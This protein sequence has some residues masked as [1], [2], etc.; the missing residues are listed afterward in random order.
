MIEAAGTSNAFQ[1]A[2]VAARRGGRVVLLGLPG[3]PG[4]LDIFRLVSSERELIGSLSHVWDEDFTAA[5][6][7]LGEGV[8][9]A[10][11]L[12]RDARCGCSKSHRAAE[13]G[14]MLHSQ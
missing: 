2:S 7:M 4:A 12:A 10:D 6:T 13:T 11:D 9:H 1:Q 8:L 3:Q 5:V 14:R